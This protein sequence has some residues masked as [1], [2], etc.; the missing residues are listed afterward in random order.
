[1]KKGIYYAVVLAVYCLVSAAA[2]AWV[3]NFTLSPIAV[4]ERKA[5]EESLH[6]VL[7]EAD[8]FSG[9]ELNEAQ[10]NKYRVLYG[11]LAEAEGF[12]YCRGLRNGRPVGS[13]Y[14]VFP[15]GY[16]GTIEMKVAV[17]PAGQVVGVKIVAQNETPGLGNK[18]AGDDFQGSGR[19]FTAQFLGKTERDQLEAKKDIQAITGATI[20]SRGVV[21]GVK[22]A[23]ELHELGQGSKR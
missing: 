5:A 12:V 19:P 21:Q 18:I 1:M 9:S 3:Y 7:P 6:L 4:C 2:L 23:L 14:S 8:S 17:D 11:K 13:I 10:R 15:K 20:S 16:A 22:D